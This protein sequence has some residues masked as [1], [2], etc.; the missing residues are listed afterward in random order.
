M[1]GSN[2]VLIKGAS[3]LL[4]L[5]LSFFISSYFFLF[6]FASLLVPFVVV[7]AVVFV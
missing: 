2:I 3:V 1:Q 5:A 7:I 6:C 4:L